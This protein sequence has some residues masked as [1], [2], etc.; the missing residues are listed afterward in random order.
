VQTRNNNDFVLA[1]FNS[2]PNEVFQTR[3]VEMGYNNNNDPRP[4]TRP[5]TASTA[6][7]ASRLAATQPRA[8]TEC[9]HV[10]KI[11]HSEILVAIPVNN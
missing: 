11:S 5:V 3:E 1:S 10:A 8:Q 7:N 9:E 6:L 2:R 4:Q